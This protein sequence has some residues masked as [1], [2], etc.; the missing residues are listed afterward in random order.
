MNIVF[1][2]R[3]GYQQPG[4]R[5]RCYGFA[6]ELQKRGFPAEVFSFV[7]HAGGNPETDRFHL[8]LREK[9]SL[10]VRGWQELAKKHRT[11]F[12]VNRFNYHT[13]V[14]WGQSLLR[15]IPYVFD[16]D[17]WEARQDT[18]YHFHLI[19]RSKADYM[20][21]IFA[22]GSLFCLAASHYLKNYLSRSHKKVYYVPSGVDTRLFT[23]SR[24]TKNRGKIIF[25][26]HG[27]INRR[28]TVDNLEFLI[29][30]FDVIHKKHPAA[31]LWIK[32]GGILAD[33][34]KEKLNAAVTYFPWSVM[35]TIPHHLD[36]IDIGIVP[37][38]ENNR[39]HRA[40]SPTKIFEYMAKGKPVIASP[41]GEAEHII[42]HRHNGLLAQDKDS[43][44]A[45]MEALI[46]ES[47][48]RVRLGENAVKTIEDTYS[49]TALGERLAKIFKENNLKEK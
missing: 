41:L 32:G 30:C 35:Q 14:P 3:E 27:M 1:V 29:E 22:R 12:V 21:R 34:L 13:F 19:P 40:K 31:E 28:E 17:D 7:D 20:T 45:A 33:R 11:V 39:F 9:L 46:R 2:T 23:P 47:H 44:V 43:F 15:K 37:L 49:M 48:L 6:G 42:R 24:G 18:G 36:S 25:S 16:M 38:R 5:I 8:G 10:L 4:A 26:W